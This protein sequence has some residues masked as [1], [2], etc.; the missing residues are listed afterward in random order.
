[1]ARFLIYTLL[2][3]GVLYTVELD[4]KTFQLQENEI[5][6]Q[7]QKKVEFEGI[8]KD[9]KYHIWSR[10]NFFTFKLQ[11][12]DSENYI[13]VRL[14]TINWLR[15][16][17]YFECEE[18]DSLKIKDLFYVKKLGKQI[19]YMNVTVKASV[20][21]CIEH[22]SEDELNEIHDEL[23]DDFYRTKDYTKDY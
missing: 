23:H 14:Y 20:L 8:I 13:K 21:E 18:G 9:L 17:N 3:F 2:F 15:R 16:V 5:Q 6:K 10:D 1:M 19:G 7:N 11:D 4:A 22:I 12:I